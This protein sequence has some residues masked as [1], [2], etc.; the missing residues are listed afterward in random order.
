VTHHLSIF[1]F[2]LLGRKAEVADLL[3]NA[4]AV[5]CTD[6][7]GRTPLMVAC[8]AGRLDIVELLLKR[9]AD[10]NAR[11]SKGTTAFMYAKSAALGSGNPAI[12]KCLV[13]F[14]AKVNTVDIHNKTALQYAREN[15]KMV[16]KFILD[17]GKKK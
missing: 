9:G 2:C 4:V 13:D 5:D 7:L 14:N 6:S 12:M 1:E 15:F 3:D 11:N 10:V 8:W 16:E 17:Q